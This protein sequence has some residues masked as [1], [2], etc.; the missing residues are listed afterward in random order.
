M[1]EGVEG[2]RK[3]CGVAASSRLIAEACSAYDAQ[4]A[5]ALRLVGCSSDQ[6][7]T[8]PN[9]SSESAA[10]LAHNLNRSRSSPSLAAAASTELQM[11]RSTS[12]GASEEDL[13]AHVKAAAERRGGARGLRLAGKGGRRQSQ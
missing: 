1:V 13:A 4:Y 11:P 8:H 7:V 3:G 9:R 5:R 10:A 6:R 2:V 12:S